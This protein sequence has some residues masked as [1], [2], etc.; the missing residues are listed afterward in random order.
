[1]LSRVVPIRLTSLLGC[2]EGL[3]DVVGEKTGVVDP[4]EQAKEESGPT[5]DLGLSCC[6]VGRSDKRLI[7][8]PWD[9]NESRA[10]SVDIPPGP[11]PGRTYDCRLTLGG[12]GEFNGL[13]E[14]GGWRMELMGCENNGEGCDCSY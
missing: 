14:V 4:C 1:M 8:E 3:L 10:P 9:D 11:S 7:Q 2:T 12:F 5:L 6:A 13:P